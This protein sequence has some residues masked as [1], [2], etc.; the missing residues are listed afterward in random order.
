MNVYLLTNSITSTVPFS[1]AFI[2]SINLCSSVKFRK[3]EIGSYIFYKNTRLIL[4]QLLRTRLR[5][6]LALAEEQSF[7]LRPDAMLFNAGCNEQVFSP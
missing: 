3:I 7:N 6:L 5:T 1:F 2:V 4:A